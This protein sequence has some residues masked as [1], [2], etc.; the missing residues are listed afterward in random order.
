MNWRKV[1]EHNAKATARRMRR[2]QA[3]HAR[4]RTIEEF[5]GPIALDE[6]RNAERKT[7]PPAP[8][9]YIHERMAWVF[10]G[11]EWA[12]WEGAAVPFKPYRQ[13]PDLIETGYGRTVIPMTPA[14]RKWFKATFPQYC[15]ED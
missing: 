6:L 10:R 13:D 8:G 5:G 9:G 11:Q 4:K 3:E 12:V 15:F 7:Y 2:E 1:R 14:A